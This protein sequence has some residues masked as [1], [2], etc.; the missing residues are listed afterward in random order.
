[1]NKKDKC[2]VV[3][4][5]INVAP[6]TLA[7]IRTVLQKQVETGVVVIPPWCEIL[8]TPTGVEIRHCR[9]EVEGSKKED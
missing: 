8:S 3:R 2:I 9:I 7:S 4:P 1:M 5:V 6:E